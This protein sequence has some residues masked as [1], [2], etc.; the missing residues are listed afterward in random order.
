[1]FACLDRTKVN[2][3]YCVESKGIPKEDIY[4]CAL[5]GFKDFAYDTHEL[6]R[7]GEQPEQ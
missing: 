1:M 7:S 5:H 2:L 4:F 6:C 3:N